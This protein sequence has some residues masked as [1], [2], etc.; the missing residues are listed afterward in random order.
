ML[1][2]SYEII[3]WDDPE[4]DPDPATNNLLHCQQPDHLGDQ[5]EFIVYELL[6]EEPV[7]VRFARQTAEHAVVGPAAARNRLYLVLFASSHKRG[8]W[9]RPV[10]GWTA[11]PAEIVDWERATGSTWRRYR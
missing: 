8:D 11:E 9:L 10:T 2:W 5:A 6:R 4:E 1:V 7:E 3:D